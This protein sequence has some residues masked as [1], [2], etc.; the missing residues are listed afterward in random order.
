VIFNVTKF[1]ERHGEQCFERE[2]FRR[3]AGL[4]TRWT[5]ELIHVGFLSLHQKYR[6]TR[7]SRAHRP[8]KDYPQLRRDLQGAIKR[9]GAKSPEMMKSVGAMHG[10]AYKNGAIEAKNKELI[11]LGISISVRCE[12]CI[13]FHTHEARTRSIGAVP[14]S[15]VKSG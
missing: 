11:A 10:A 8:N 6:I 13:T 15:V 4:V 3:F 2:S 7:P 12:D 1:S 5:D 9:L 14:G